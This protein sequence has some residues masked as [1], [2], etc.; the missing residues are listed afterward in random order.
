ML[1]NN[2]PPYEF[3]KTF[4]TRV[5]PSPFVGFPANHVLAAAS[6]R[7]RKAH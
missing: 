7:R 3:Q 1:L 4:I 5:V 6:I 2:I